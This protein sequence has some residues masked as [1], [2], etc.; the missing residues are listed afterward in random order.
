MSD[1]NQERD[2]FEEEFGGSSGIRPL[3]KTKVTPVKNIDMYARS[4][5][6]I[7]S[8]MSLKSATEHEFRTETENEADKAIDSLGYLKL[9]TSKEICGVPKIMTP[10]RF[11]FLQMSLTN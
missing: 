1:E 3:E 8:P 4:E 7:L 5:S 10:E 9:E 2:I 11:I 6:E